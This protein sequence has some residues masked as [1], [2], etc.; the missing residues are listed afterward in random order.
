MSIWVVHHIINEGEA[1][2]AAVW[3]WM[4]SGLSGLEDS[5]ADRKTKALLT[6]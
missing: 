4:G 6:P 2:Q 3:R 1:R 5:T